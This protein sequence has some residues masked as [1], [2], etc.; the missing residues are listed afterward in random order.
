MAGQHPFSNGVQIPTAAV[1]HLMFAKT[2]FKFNGTFVIINPAP[3]FTDIPFGR[4]CRSLNG[5]ALLQGSP[6]REGLRANGRP[7]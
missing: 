4:A 7:D 1:N 3:N 6:E 2:T 5:R